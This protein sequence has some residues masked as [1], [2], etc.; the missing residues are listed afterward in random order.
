MGFSYG[1]FRSHLMRV[2]NSRMTEI[3]LGYLKTI[4]L[5]TNQ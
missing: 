5:R 3:A 1:F 4:I 2:A